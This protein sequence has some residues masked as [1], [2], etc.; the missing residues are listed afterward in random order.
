[1]VGIA[2]ALWTASSGF[3]HL[4]EALNIAYDE[5]DGR[6]FV[7]KRALALAMTLGA[8]VLT[9]AVGAVLT[10]A[11]SSAITGVASIGAQIVGW[12]AV[13]ALITFGL[14]AVYRYGPDRDEPKWRWASWGAGL[15]VVSAVIVSIGFSLYVANFASYNETYG[16]LGAIVVTLMWLYLVAIVVIVGAELN[17]EMEPQT[18]RD[19]TRGHAKPMGRA[20]PR[21]RR[22]LGRPVFFSRP[23]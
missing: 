17:A 4:I 5:T 11:G 19:S 3:A 16:S 18:L 15:A 9:A 8:L 2:V 7:K 14:T 21:A 1:M 6:T 13:A 12:L 20:A 22:R 10:L 23:P